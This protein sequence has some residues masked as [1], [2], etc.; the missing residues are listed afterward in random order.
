MSFYFVIEKLKK[1]PLYI[2]ILNKRVDVIFLLNIMKGV[3][4]M[5]KDEARTIL[6]TGDTATIEHVLRCLDVTY[7]A[8]AENQ[9]FEKL[10]ET[11][12]A[13]NLLLRHCVEEE[14]KTKHF[15]KIAD[16]APFKDVC[17]ACK[18]AG[19]MYK[20]ARATKGIKCKIC[21]GQKEVWV[22]CEDC[23]GTTI[24][25]K[26]PDSKG[27]TCRKCRKFYENEP[28]LEKREKIK[29]KIPIK[30]DLC[31]GS[32][33]KRILIRSFEIE[34][35]TPC[36]K[37]RG[38][39]FLTPNPKTKPFK[40]KKVKRT[41]PSPDNPVLT[42][43]IMEKLSEEASPPVKEEMINP[44]GEEEGGEPTE[45]VLKDSEENP[46]EKSAPPAE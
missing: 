10:D 9:D 24:F 2:L 44:C 28:D 42:K 29:G 46:E 41:P 5:Q 26:K 11:V 27:I 37:C 33:E 16:V 8:M 45:C 17:P 32:G 3:F 36:K 6:G 4:P 21:L 13:K 12:E 7:W 40:K 25:K 31:R 38:L 35:T 19:E 43:E 30:C 18:G 15:F 23:G 39:G 14:M 22:K 1:F 34:S 20:F